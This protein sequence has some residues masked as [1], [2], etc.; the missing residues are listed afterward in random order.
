MRHLRLTFCA[1]LAALFLAAGPAFAAGTFD[2]NVNYGPGLPEG[3]VARNA[4]QAAVDA[5]SARITSPVQINIDADLTPKDANGSPFGPGVVGTTNF[6][7]YSSDLSDIN[8]NFDT[9]RN[10]MAARASRPGDSILTA[11]PNSAQVR[12]NVPPASTFDNR[13]L[14]VLR[15]NQK[16]LGVITPT[17]DPNYGLADGFIRFNSGF[18]FDYNRSDGV[19][20]NKIDFQTVATHEIGHLLGFLSDV[21]D[22]DAAPNLAS[23][24]LTTL[25]LFRFGQAPANAGEF[26]NF[27]RELRPGIP[28][29]TSD[30]TNNYPMSTGL[31]NGDG[32]Q[33][34]HWKDDAQN[35]GQYI[36][37][38]DP[39]VNFGA[40]EDL[41]DADIRAM[42]LIGY[43]TVPEPAMGS[44]IVIIAIA[45]LA[46]RKRR[47][48]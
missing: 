47:A 43:D 21:D 36:G 15:A 18:S 42:E 40:F 9:V 11:L 22:F 35:G 30:T 28:S 23:D 10:A 41:T 37:I 32:N 4:F 27:A 46:G 19:D 14:V 1:A 48:A 25:D 33:A 24:N 31:E 26:T 6:A 34:S 7:S 13:T 17:S 45:L 16:A 39:V 8:L 3:S 29:V 38:M 44:F 5:W 20:F 12:A 2:L